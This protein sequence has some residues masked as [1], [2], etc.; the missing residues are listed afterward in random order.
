[1]RWREEPPGPGP[2]SWRS[3]VCTVLFCTPAQVWEGSSLV[4]RVPRILR[5]MRYHVL[6]RYGRLDSVVQGA[7]VE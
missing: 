5:T 1:M 2:A 4:F 6:V 7:M 3:V